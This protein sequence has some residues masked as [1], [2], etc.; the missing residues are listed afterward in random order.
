M[1]NSTAEKLLILIQHPDKRRF[2]VSK[3]VKSIAL[4]GSILL[5]LTDSKNLTIENRKLIVKTK[6]SDLSQAHQWV[7]EEIE[8][9]PVTRKVKTWVARFS[10]KSGKIQKELLTE[11]ENQG[12]IQINHKRFLGIKYYRTQLTNLEIREKII[13]DIRDIIFKESKISQK[14]SML[15]GLIGA[16][17]MH[18]IIAKDKSEIKVCKRKLAEII[19][20]DALAQEVDQVIKE[21]QAVIIATLT[22]SAFVTASTLQVMVI[23]SWSVNAGLLLLLNLSQ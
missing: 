9:S 11:L 15:L 23:I 17:R 7:L 1:I 13:D 19:K 3:Y 18:R 8:G 4:I 5:D 14:N 10:Q 2:I 16:C 21:T 6:N 20:S 22:T 12:I